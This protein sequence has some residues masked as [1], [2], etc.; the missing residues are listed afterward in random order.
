MLRFVAFDPVVYDP[1]EATLLFV[2]AGP[3]VAELTF[4]IAF[5]AGV[6][7]VFIRTNLGQT[8]NLTYTG[9]WESLPII[10]IT[11]PITNPTIEN[12]TTGEKLALTYTVLNHK[13]VTIDLRYGYKTI[14]GDTGNNLIGTLSGDSDLA[15]FHLAPDPEA[16]LGVNQIRVLGQSVNANTRVTMRY[17]VRYFGI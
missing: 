5:V 10:E 8:F 2:P 16:P 6:G 13:T 7:I 3:I 15:T 11:G 12:L 1:D 14:I 4:P 17:Y 9:T